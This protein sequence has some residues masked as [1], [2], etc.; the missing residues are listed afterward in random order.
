SRDR[1]STQV[2]QDRSVVSPQNERFVFSK[3][4]QRIV[5]FAQASRRL[6]QRIENR[7]QIE[8][9][10]ADDLEY[11]GGGG[12]LLEGFA[13]LV[14]QA[15]VLDG[16]DGLSGEGLDE[17]DLLIIERLGVTASGRYRTDDIVPT[18]HR[19]RDHRVVSEASSEPRAGGRRGGIAEHGRELN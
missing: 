9:R 4:D 13:Q 16:D 8:C 10:A 1:Q 7:L 6:D 15:R 18:K 17:L 19:S 11:V 3:E 14:E 5:G 2:S 12:L